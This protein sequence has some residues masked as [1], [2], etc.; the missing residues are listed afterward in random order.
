ML[1][2]RNRRRCLKAALEALGRLPL[3]PD[4]GTS[5][6]EVI[7]VDNASRAPATAP[8]ILPNGLAVRIIR[9]ATN[10][11]A[12]GRNVGARAAANDWLIMLDDD[13]WPL[14]DG[15]F[16]VIADPDPDV[17]A[18]GAEIL[19]PGGRHEDGGLPEV[20]IGCGAAIRRDAFLEVGGYDTAFGYYAE[21]YDL[22]AKLIRAGWR[23][24]HDLR[25]RVR[26]E[27][28]TAGRDMDR[29]LHHL[30]RNNGWVAQRYVP[31]EEKADRLNEVITRYGRIAIR[32]GAA[33]GFCR[34]MADL[35]TTLPQQPDRS[36]S[37]ERFDRFTGLAHVRAVLAEEPLL[38]GGA[39]VAIVDA[40]KNAWVVERVL[41]EFKVSIADCESEAEV[42]VIGTLSPGPM[43]DAMDRRCEEHRPV[44]CP[45]LPAA[46]PARSAACDVSS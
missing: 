24:A 28:A 8:A 19:L 42:L 26:H 9:R 12:A 29:I 36:M 22:C 23:I 4:G 27:K 11:G 32:E 30:V 34:G 46:M 33:E 13:S 6:A 10:E 1:P 25:F 7:V 44:I 31:P 14:D 45:W 41:R 43:L 37:R 20:I 16:A 40:G 5:G 35:L 39:S 17:A 38:H 15:H 2:T 21:E 3:P 18:I